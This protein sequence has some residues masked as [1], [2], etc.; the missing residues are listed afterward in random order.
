[1][2]KITFNQ[3]T[4][5]YAFDSRE[6]NIKYIAQQELYVNDL[7]KVRGYVY[8]NQIYELFGV[9]WDPQRENLCL[10]YNGNN[11]IDFNIHSVGNG[12]EI[13]IG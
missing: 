1:M 3:N 13:T 6:F 4:S 2:F 12:F 7:L 8:I 10:L 9:K 11:H 5:V